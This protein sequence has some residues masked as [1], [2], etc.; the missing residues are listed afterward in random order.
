MNCDTYLAMLE[1]LPVEELAYGN[2]REHAANCRDCDRVTQ[3][4]AERE[5]NLVMAFGGLYPSVQ[6]GSITARALELSRR[7]R[8]A[9]YYRIGLGVATVATF[10]FVIVTRRVVP[11]R[12]MIETFRLQCLSPDQAIEVLRKVTSPAVSLS[13]RDNSLGIIRVAGPPGEIERVRSVLVRY[14]NATESQC[15]LRLTIPQVIRLP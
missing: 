12:A 13:A 2:A 15:G 14:Y 11:Q 5:R 9:L 1:T 6:A 8:I 3:V 4:V 7:R 10:F